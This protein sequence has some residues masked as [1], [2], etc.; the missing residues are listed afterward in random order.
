METIAKVRADCPICGKR[1]LIPSVAFE[2]LPVLCNALHSD[3]ASARSAGTGRFELRFCRGCGHLFNAAFEKDRIGYTQGYNSSLHFS[4]RFVAFADT[5]VE[6]LRTTYLL[7]GKTVVDIGCG[8]GNFL[9]RLCLASGAEGV[10]FDKSFE[11]NRNEVSSGVRFIKDWFHN[12]YADIRPDFVS[13]RH[14]IEHIAEPVAFLLALRLHPGIGPE[15]VFYFECPNALYTLR[16]LGI[17][18]LIYEHVSYFTPPSLRTAF[19]VAGFEV[20]NEET[21]FGEQYL[22]IE[23]KLS[24]G[25]QRVRPPQASDIEPLVL[26]F[27]SAY[28]EKTKHWCEY[29]DARDPGRAVIWGAGS[30]GVTFINVV[31]NADQMGALVDVNPYKQGRFAPGTATPIIAPEEL[32]ER[33]VQSVIVMNPLY[34]SEIAG[35]LAALG[36]SPE[37]VIA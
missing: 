16:D 9:K 31:A 27:D 5:L 4:P 13:C 17:W 19:E 7:A 36:I 3:S 15:T 37:I 8:K 22:C 14:V 2:A 32:C 28:H 24:S 10:G 30:K 26:D 25:A 35:A 29:L 23:A 12:S 21:S 1:D 34:Q 18:D 6:R 20:L 11:E 33:P